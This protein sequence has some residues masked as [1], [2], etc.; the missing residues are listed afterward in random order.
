MQTVRGAGPRHSHAHGHG[1]HLQRLLTAW[2]MA[3]AL[4]PAAVAQPAPASAAA[5]GP[6]SR[7]YAIEIKTGTSWDAAKPAHE[8]AHFREHSANL[9]HLREQGALVM[10]ARYAD[11]GLIVLRAASEADAHAMMQVD[12]S[13]Q[14][15][16]FAYEL[17][18][19]VVFYGGAVAAPPRRP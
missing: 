4:C 1:R 10:G 7:L 6:P 5:A 9:R 14:G 13:I 19:F 8:Q 17:H 3:L 2:C 18:E 11:K 16:V 15:R 12:P